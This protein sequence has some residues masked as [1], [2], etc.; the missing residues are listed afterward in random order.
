MVEL[1]ELEGEIHRKA[2]WNIWHLKM[3]RIQL[4]QRHKKARCVGEEVRVI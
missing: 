3:Q 1:Y 4:K 2:S